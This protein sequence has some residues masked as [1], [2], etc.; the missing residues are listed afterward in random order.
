MKK[1]K[2]LNAVVFLIFLLLIGN[3][4]YTNAQECGLT[5]YTPG[6]QNI[7]VK[8]DPGEFIRV[9]VVYVTFPNDN[10]PNY[11]HSIWEP[12]PDPEIA[13]RP[14]NPYPLTNGR[15]IH[16]EVGDPND[17][18]MERYP[19]YTI[20]DYFCE[21]SMGDYDVIGDEYYLISEHTEGE[22]KSYGWKQGRMN[23]YVLEYLDELH[24]YEFP[25]YLYDNWSKVGDQ[26]YFDQ[27]DGDADM[28]MIVYRY[29][30]DN[31][32]VGNDNYE[33][34]WDAGTGGMATLA[35]N[36]AIYF[37]GVK[38]GKDQG[39]TSTN[40][41]HNTT[42]TE[43]IMIHEYSHKIFGNQIPI[44]GIH[45]NHGMMTPSH[46]MSTYVMSP[47]ERCADVVDYTDYTYIH[48]KSVTLHHLNDYVESGEVLR[49][50]NN[51]HIGT[52]SSVCHYWVTNHQKISVYDGVLRGGKDCYQLNFAEQDPYC[53]DG[54][55]IIIE[56]EKQHNNCE[57][58]NWPYDIISA[59]GRYDWFQ[60][61]QVYVPWQ[62][63]FHEMGGNY[64]IYEETIPGSVNKR[65]EGRDE[66]QKG[67]VQ[68]LTNDPC[69]EGFFIEYQA[70]GDKE[71][72]FNMESD[73]IFSPYS[74]PSSMTCDPNFGDYPVTIALD[75]ESNGVIDVKVYVDEGQQALDD[76]PP[77]RPKNF[78][79]SKEM[80]S[81]N[82]YRPKLTWDANIE[83][84]FI[85]GGTY[86]IFRGMTTD[87]NTE[88]SY[89]APWGVVPAGVTELTDYS[90]TLYSREFGSGA[91]QTYFQ[92]YSYK[93]TA[94]DNSYKESVESDKD[95]IYGWVDPCA[96]QE[97]I[98][99]N[100]G[101]TPTE[102]SLK[103]NYPNPFNPT[104]NIQFDLPNDVKVSIKVYDITGKEVAVLVNEFKKAGS[105]IVAFN[106][107]KLSSGVYFYKM[108][109]GS[110]KD[111]KRMIFVK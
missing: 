70:R 89:Y 1:L 101:E 52:Q 59:E 20:S 9:L 53:G 84:D 41:M 32:E 14:V 80:I 99:L 26:W 68:L 97:N 25:W 45:T 102:F 21:M 31:D 54:K 61:R 58:L 67:Y 103:Q 110:F 57:N 93:I 95:V 28:V 76:L 12:P 22:C 19:D 6:L 69:S 23:Q 18:F 55:G 92:S 106:G 88:P 16:N 39:I 11:L 60:D 13:T 30:P 65:Y 3:T 72:A 105:Y 96:P 24:N 8:N 98:I 108:K 38:I 51:G 7:P 47:W 5:E 2:L 78:H 73:R 15:L 48:E 91:C 83:P 10:T 64:S 34:F 40:R 37:D 100:P 107:S 63:Y 29:L 66:Y 36:P 46:D 109:A 33:W 74:N 71:D 86:H 62:N 94:V 56:I 42:H 104:T 85:D 4:S 79:V 90:V 75:G 44:S 87:C 81:S 27:P 50:T 111:I 17:Y 49:I 43:L 82:S 35:I 77:S